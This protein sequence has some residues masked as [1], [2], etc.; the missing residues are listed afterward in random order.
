ML[1]HAEQCLKE[2]DLAY[3][4]VTLPAGDLGFGAMFTYDIEVWLP[5]Q[6]KYREISSCSDTGTFQTRRAA[7]RT[8]SKGGQRGLAA[9]LNG[10]ALPIGRTLAALLEQHQQPDGS[11]LIPEPLVP[12]TGFLRVAADGT[13][14]S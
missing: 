1:G 11:V 13:P 3:R 8:K 6:G 7:I 9:A 12:Y 10:S 14:Q 5:S 4:V 2:L